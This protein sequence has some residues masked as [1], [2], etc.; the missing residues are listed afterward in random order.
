MIEKVKNDWAMPELEVL[1]VAEHTLSGLNT[2][3]DGGGGSS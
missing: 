1:D 3:L 2:N